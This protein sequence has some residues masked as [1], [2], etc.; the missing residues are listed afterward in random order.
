MVFIR[1]N[2]FRPEVPQ[3]SR[4]VTTRLITPSQ[5]AWV[6]V[7]EALKLLRSVYRQ[8]HQLR[9]SGRSCERTGNYVGTTSG[10]V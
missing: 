1:T 7:N 3:Y 6:I 2:P 5:D 8:G 9:Q 10:F 4:S